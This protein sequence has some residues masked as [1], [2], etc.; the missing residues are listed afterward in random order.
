MHDE[1]ESLHRDRFA[2]LSTNDL[3]EPDH[4]TTRRLRSSPLQRFER[5]HL[6]HTQLQR[7]GHRLQAL[8]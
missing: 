5:D 2:L 8:N 7:I 3:A 4:H 6:A 1:V